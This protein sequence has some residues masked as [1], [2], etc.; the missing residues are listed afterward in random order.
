MQDE[1]KLVCLEPWTPFRPVKTN[2][3]AHELPSVEQNS[4][5]NYTLVTKISK[6]M[7][8]NKANPANP[9]GPANRLRKTHKFLTKWLKTNAF[10]TLNPVPSCKGHYFLHASCAAL[11]KVPSKSYS[12]LIKMSPAHYLS[13]PEPLSVLFFTDRIFARRPAPVWGLGLY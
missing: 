2:T 1:Q 13:N 12:S 4:Y 3:F 5:E 7:F 9:P 11:Q 8:K 6:R 10:R